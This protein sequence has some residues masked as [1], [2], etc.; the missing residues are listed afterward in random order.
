[1][2]LER[3]FSRLTGDVTVRDGTLIE[4]YASLFGREDQG[5]DVVGG[6]IAQVRPGSPEA[7]RVKE[8]HA[9][10]L[11]LAPELG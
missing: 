9:R 10:V 4:G 1:M 3:K 8:L 2:E 7:Q 11:E 5:R 6:A